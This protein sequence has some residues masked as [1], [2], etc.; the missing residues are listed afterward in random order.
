MQL[1][2]L[3]S[4][5]SDF[6]NLFEVCLEVKFTEG[7]DGDLITVHA[8]V[9]ASSSDFIPVFSADGFTGDALDQGQVLAEFFKFSFD[10]HCHSRSVREVISEL[11]VEL[12]AGH[13]PKVDA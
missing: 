10:D 2:L 12:E 8:F 11:F 1:E 13:M 6:I 4:A 7:Q 9:I 5:T 3:L